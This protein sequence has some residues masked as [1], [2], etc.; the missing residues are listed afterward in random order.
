MIC[1]AAVADMNFAERA[2]LSVRIVTALLYVAADAVVD[3]FHAVTSFYS[4]TLRNL[5]K[6]IPS[7]LTF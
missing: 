7:A 4:V 2:V 6:S 3:T 5:C 1:R